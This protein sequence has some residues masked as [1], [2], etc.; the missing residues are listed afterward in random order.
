MNPVGS[1]ADGVRACVASGALAAD[2]AQDAAAARL[3]ALIGALS[4][5]RGL[6]GRAETPRGVWLHGPVGTGKSMLTD[7]AFERAPAPKRRV[8]FHDFMAEAH[9]WIG[10]WR[11][12]DA[13]GR[14]RAFGAASHFLKNMGEDPIPPLAAAIARDARLLALDEMEIT[15]IADAMLVGRLFEHLFARGVALIATS[16][17]A[18]EDLYENGINRQLFLPFVALIRVRLDVIRLDSGRD[19]RRQALAGEDL[20]LAPVTAE[21]RARFE[22]LWRRMTA[23]AGEHGE[24]LSVTGRIVQV[25]RAAAGCCRFTF[26]AL[27]GSALGASDYLAIARRY[28]ALFLEDAPVLAREDRDKARRFVTLIDA[29]YEADCALVALAEAEPE[30]LYAEGDYAFEF[31]RAASRIAEMRRRTDKA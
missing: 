23:G 26:D 28:R 24:A 29:L 1:V 20:W 13:R 17:R 11:A 19:Y 7:M 3:D 31:R 21:T 9:A 16:N 22:D 15:D 18:P 10:R 5:R 14:R 4:A 8:H 6:F 30:R 27:C 25:P 12:L 2:P